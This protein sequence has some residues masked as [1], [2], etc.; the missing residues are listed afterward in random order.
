MRP[1]TIFST[2]LVAA[3]CSSTLVPVGVAASKDTK[4]EAAR[5][6]VG[7]VSFDRDWTSGFGDLEKLVSVAGPFV[8]VGA[9]GLGI[10]LR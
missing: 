9:H 10:V 3:I 2:F 5:C 4:G 6:E 1:R 8:H 7:E